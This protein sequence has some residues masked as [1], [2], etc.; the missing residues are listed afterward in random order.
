VSTDHGL[1]VCYYPFAL[2]SVRRSRSTSVAHLSLLQL[3]PGKS[4]QSK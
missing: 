4:K 1:C 2:E 3:L